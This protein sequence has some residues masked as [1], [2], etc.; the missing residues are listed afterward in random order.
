MRKILSAL[1]AGLALLILAGPAAAQSGRW[2]RYQTSGLLQ[3]STGTSTTAS[4]AQ[5]LSGAT[6]CMVQFT[7]SSTSSA[8]VSLEG[9]IDGATYWTA[10]ATA[11]NPAAATPVT[12]A[13]PCMPFLRVNPSAHASGTLYT[14]LAWRNVPSD[15]IGH[16]W[17]LLTQASVSFGAGSF[18]SVTDSGLTS[19]RCP[20]VTTGGLFNDS[21]NALCTGSLFT[22]PSVKVSDLTAT[23]VPYATTA[24]QLIDDSAFTYT[25]SGGILAATTHKGGYQ[26]TSTA[27]S[28]DGAIAV[29]NGTYFITKGS[30]LGSSTLATPTSTTHDGYL[31]RIVSTTAFTHVITFTTGTVNKITGT[32]ITFT[33]AAVG[34]SITLQAYQGVWYIVATTGTITIT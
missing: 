33:S 9:S 32:T 20:L 21:G 28:G 26:A 6:A 34:D 30:A 31:L 19:G 14:Y 4:S 1:A 18:T 12:Y 8:T 22:L 25:T 13:G 16:E 15:P 7:S 24:G 29:A 10:L 11:T 23:R 17:K 3:T 5:D 27:L 2:Q